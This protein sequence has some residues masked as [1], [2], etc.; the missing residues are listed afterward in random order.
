MEITGLFVK[1]S[2]NRN[3]KIF[4]VQFEF[5]ENSIMQ[6]FLLNDSDFNCKDKLY[7]KHK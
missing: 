1:S 6:L 4:M 7:S 2:L 3:R 5:T